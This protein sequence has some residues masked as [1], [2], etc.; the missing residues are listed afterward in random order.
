[1]VIKASARKRESDVELILLAIFYGR[2]SLVM[3]QPLFFDQSDDV[4]TLPEGMRYREQLIGPTE[5]RALLARVR[6]LPFKEFEFHGHKGKR[7]TVSFGW[8]YVFSGRGRLK[9]AY[10]I[11][12]FIFPLRAIAAKFA[13]LE[14]ESLQHV[15][16]IECGPG[17]G[18]GWHRDKP[19]FGEVIG[20]SLLAPCVL[21]FRRKLAAE[22]LDKTRP[23]NRTTWQRVNL[24]AAPRSAYHLTG[25]ART[26]W[27]HSI[28]S[29]EQLRYSI[30]FRTLH[31]L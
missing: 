22:S 4:E 2:L 26:Q 9:K 11:P 1:V 6:E 21:R 16:V 13:Q 5:E 23:P 27:E 30:T 19:V 24:P 14:A 12:E 7:R 20:V 18:I 17:A 10:D 8:Q 25:R 29:V 15:L 3:T 31:A 28:L